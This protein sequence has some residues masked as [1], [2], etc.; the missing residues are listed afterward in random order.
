MYESE[1]SIR[2]KIR[3]AWKEYEEAKAANWNAQAEYCETV[4]MTLEWVL[5][6]ND[7]PLKV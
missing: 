2:T 6:E 1:D 5:G 4:A 7:D 3:Q